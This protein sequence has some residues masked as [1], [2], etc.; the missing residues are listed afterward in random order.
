MSDDVS[1]VITDTHYQALDT[2]LRAPRSIKKLHQVV[3]DAPFTDRL[4]CAN[5]DLGIV[6]LLLVNKKA[7][8]ID[9]VALSNTELAKG[10]VSVSAKPFHEIR[11]PLRAKDNC[12]ARAVK[13]KEHQLVDDWQYLFTPVLTPDQARLNQAGASI[14]CSLVWPLTS[15]DGGAMIFS[16]YQPINYIDDEHLTFAKRYAAL[17]DKHLERLT[18]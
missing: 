1:L 2:Q 4:L 14:E 13:T 3:V 11:I 16:F 10:A 15:G 18:K 17:V 7:H 9:R 12:I 6:V 5:I 8:T